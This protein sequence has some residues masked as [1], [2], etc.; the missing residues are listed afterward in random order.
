MN[1]HDTA[2]GAWEYRMPA[3]ESEFTPPA[4]EERTG[5]P[6]FEGGGRS[7]KSTKL[8]RLDRKSVG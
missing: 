3:P 4:P 1:E 5:A 2:L 8:K 7:G 6:P